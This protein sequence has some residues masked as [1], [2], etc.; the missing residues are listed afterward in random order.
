MITRALL[1]PNK[2]TVIRRGK[3]INAVAVTP[4]SSVI[5]ENMQDQNSLGQMFQGHTPSK[6]D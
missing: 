5:V 1:G 3:G 6:E 4:G 2:I